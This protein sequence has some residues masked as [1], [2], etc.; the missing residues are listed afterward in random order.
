MK[1]K[2]SISWSGGKDSAFA[3]FKAL[4]FQ[5]VEVVSLHTGFNDK[6][7]RVGM[8]GTHESLIEAQA[9][10]LKLP[11]HKIYIPANSSNTSYEQAMLLFYQ[12]QKKAGVDAIIFGDIFLEDL[13][14]YRESLTGKAGLNALFPLW[15]NDTHTL[16]ADFLQEGFKTTICAANA[17]LLDKEVAGKLLDYYFLENL[18]EEVDPCGENGEFHTFV[19]DGPLFSA[20]IAFNVGEIVSKSYLLGA[21]SENSL[22]FWFAELE[23]KTHLAR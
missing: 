8:H 1:K 11:L 16:I 5:E 12:E 4:Q 14:T 3:L 23:A 7:R 2:V 18:P 22:K 17:K 19:H 9:A 6:L 20:P 10:A 15:G 21:G 13:K